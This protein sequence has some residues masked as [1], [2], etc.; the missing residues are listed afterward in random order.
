[1]VGQAVSFVD[2]VAEIVLDFNFAKMGKLSDGI[3]VEKEIV[4][5]L[6]EE[7]GLA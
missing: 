5:I 4:L 6:A 3:A 1:L 2:F 7:E